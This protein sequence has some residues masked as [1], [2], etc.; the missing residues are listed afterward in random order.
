MNKLAIIGGGSWGT[1]L[2]IV[3]AR[4]SRPAALWVYERDLA[5]RM[6][7]TR[8]NEAFLPGFSLPENVQ[9]V[10]DLAEAL[11]GANTVLTVM[12]SHHCRTLYRQML[13]YLR[14]EMSFVSATKGLETDSRLRISEVIRE[15][16]RER[17]EPRL[18][19]LSGPTFAREVAAGSPTAVVVASADLAL[20][21]AIQHDFSGPTFRLYTNSDVAG[22]EY[23]AAL[24]NVIAIGAGVCGGL[25]LGSNS[26]AALVTRGLAEISRLACACGGQRETLAGLAGLGDLVLTCHGALSRNRSVGIELAAGRSL[27]D[28]VNSMR[29]VAEGI[30][31]TQ[32]AV[33]LAE[34]HGVEMPITAQMHSMLFEGRSPRDAIRELMLRPFKREIE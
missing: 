8:E 26:I 20:A 29:M 27:D 10:N 32:A 30:K 19:V 25:G 33:V 31:T 1:A 28:I 18:A 5:E 7:E 22:V 13:A 2:A 4:E 15:V 14:P 17:F 9:P 12:P 11:D 3:L 24:K 34:R 16:C 21:G 6:R 23:G